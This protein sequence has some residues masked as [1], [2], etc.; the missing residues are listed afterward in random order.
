M[1]AFIVIPEQDPHIQEIFAQAGK[2]A[3]GKDEFT[4]FMGLLP[5]DVAEKLKAHSIYLSDLKEKGKLL[6][7]SVTHDFKDAIIVY[8][9]ENLEEAKRLADGD[10]FMKSKIFTGYQIKALHHWL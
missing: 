2:E 10:P 6:F 4:R 7:A 1:E 9:A 3:R 5:E 8:A